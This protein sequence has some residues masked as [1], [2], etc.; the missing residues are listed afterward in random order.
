MKFEGPW[1]AYEHMKILE[2]LKKYFMKITVFF[3]WK[4]LSYG[5]Y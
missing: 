4:K 2:N 3:H 1:I 5:I